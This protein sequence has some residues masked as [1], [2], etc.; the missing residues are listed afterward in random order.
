[1]SGSEIQS[2]ANAIVRYM[3][4]GGS[5]VLA[6]CLL[7][8]WRLPGDTGDV[9]LYFT[10]LAVAVSGIMIYALHRAVPYPC[11]LAA[12]H[13]LRRFIDPKAPTHADHAERRIDRRKADAP[14]QRH[15]DTWGSEVHFL[16]CSAW[17]ILSA[18]LVC[19]IAESDCLRPWCLVPLAVVLLGA[20]VRHDWRF[21]EEEDLSLTLQT[22][23]GSS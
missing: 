20:A 7:R 19:V 21:M 2:F 14:I 1:M 5:F 15:F 12:L 13:R 4:G 17:G 9:S 16:Y 22:D 11:I 8:E 6:L 23:G 18:T 10:T 3:G